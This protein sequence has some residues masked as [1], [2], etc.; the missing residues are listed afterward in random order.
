M[1]S[2]ASIIFSARAELSQATSLIGC[3][4]GYANLENSP[5]VF[6]QT[7]TLLP[8][9]STPGICRSS[10]FL[11][12]LQ[13]IVRSLCPDGHIWPSACASPLSHKKKGNTTYAHRSE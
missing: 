13:A 5:S 8:I 1:S 3:I 4:Q 2:F 12:Q 7:C 10:R 6:H 11:R 9:L